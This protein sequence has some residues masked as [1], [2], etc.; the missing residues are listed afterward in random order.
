MR[1]PWRDLLFLHGHVVEPILAP[2]AVAPEERPATASE[3]EPPP[4]PGFGRRSL[5]A[6]RLCLGIGDGAIRTQ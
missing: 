4:A 6:L 2:V 1:W 5:L 3:M